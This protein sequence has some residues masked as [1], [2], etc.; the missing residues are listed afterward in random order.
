MLFGR[1]RSR[2]GKTRRHHRAEARSPPVGWQARCD[3]RSGG[4]SIVRRAPVPLFREPALACGLSH[5]PYLTI[6]NDL[7]P[8]CFACVLSFAT[9]LN[10]RISTRI[11]NSGRGPES[12]TDIARK[13][14]V[15]GVIVT[16]LTWP[17][18]AAHWTQSTVIRAAAYALTGM[19]RNLRLGWHLQ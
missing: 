19:A 12:F 2:W 8:M 15:P 3:C 13:L 10:T 7:A 14:S 5:K 18:A 16:R 9:Q 1:Q 4:R 11:G 17:R 6:R